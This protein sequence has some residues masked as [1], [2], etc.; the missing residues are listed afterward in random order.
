MF[1]YKKPHFKP[2]TVQEKVEASDCMTLANNKNLLRLRTSPLVDSSQE[3]QRLTDHTFK[4]DTFIFSS[5]PLVK[6]FYYVSLGA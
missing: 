3:C 2:L 5:L 6:H 4:T 1:I